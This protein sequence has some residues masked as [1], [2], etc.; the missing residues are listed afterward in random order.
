MRICVVIPTYNEK[1]NVAPLLDRMRKVGLQDLHVLFV[2]DASP[3]GTAE[4]VR[5]EMSRDKSVQLLEREGKKGIGSA[6]L[7]GFRKAI[8]TLSPEMLVEMDADLQHPPEVIPELAAAMQRGADV[9]LASRKVKGGGTVGWSLWRRVVSKGANVLAEAILGLEVKDSTSGFRALNQKAALSLVGAQLPTPAYSF[10]VASL[11]YMKKRRMKI[12][13][14]PFVFET[15]R[16]G[17]SKMGLGEVV[18]FF[19]DIWKVRFR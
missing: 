12:V 10:Q 17:K 1:E 11:Y 15:R 18:G 9:V 19:L 14:I 6:H 5:E 13:E 3:D 7:D 8:E 4:A 16:A 2:D